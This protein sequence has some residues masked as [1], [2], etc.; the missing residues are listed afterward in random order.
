M[1]LI[2]E[3]ILGQGRSALTFQAGND[4]PIAYEVASSTGG[5]GGIRTPET[6]TRLLV[7][8]TSAFNH[9]ATSPQCAGPYGKTISLS[10]ILTFRL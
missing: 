10:A 2:I 1:F 8:K 7:F 4:W 6:L 3:G 5:E 9:S